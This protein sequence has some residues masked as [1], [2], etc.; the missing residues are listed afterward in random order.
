MAQSGSKLEWA[1][2]D[3]SW[4]MPYS[5]THLIVIKKKYVVAVTPQLFTGSGFTRRGKGVL[6]CIMPA[7]SLEAFWC[8]SGGWG[9]SVWLEWVPKTF[10]WVNWMM[11]SAMHRLI[12]AIWCDQAVGIDASCVGDACSKVCLWWFYYIYLFMLIYHTVVNVY[13]ATLYGWR[14]LV[15]Y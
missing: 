9:D 13:A 8:G 14:A 7:E 3:T 4:T 2:W 10:P 15:P 1:K 11:M 12:G 6:P 5:I